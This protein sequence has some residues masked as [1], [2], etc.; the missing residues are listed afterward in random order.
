MVCVVSVTQLAEKLWEVLHLLLGGLGMIF[1]RILQPDWKMLRA[2]EVDT[3]DGQL[4]DRSSTWLH[5]RVQV[6]QQLCHFSVWPHADPPLSWH[7]T[8]WITDNNLNS[9]KHYF[10]NAGRNTIWSSELKN[11]PNLCVQTPS[12]LM[13]PLAALGNSFT[14]QLSFYVLFYFFM[15]AMCVG[16]HM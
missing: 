4:T 2:I 15:T 16:R 1:C 5:K 11:L 12:L 8:A 14:G 7:S 10:W 3:A 13:D 6:S 9:P